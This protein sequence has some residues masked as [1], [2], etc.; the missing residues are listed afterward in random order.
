M[1]TKKQKKSFSDIVYDIALVI[2]KGLGNIWGFISKPWQ[3]MDAFDIVLNFVLW[4]LGIFL[5][6]ILL[7]CV[8][9]LFKILIL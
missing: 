4:G 6:A 7:I 1:K 3:T 9:Y 2:W 8:V 5:L